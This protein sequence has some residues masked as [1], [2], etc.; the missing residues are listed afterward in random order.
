MNVQKF[1]DIEDTKVRSKIIREI[2]KK[3]GFNSKQISVRTIYPKYH[4]LTDMIL[5]TIKDKNIDIDNIKEIIGKYDFVSFD[6]NTKNV[7]YGYK[8]FFDID[9][10]Y[11]IKKK[12]IK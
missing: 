7:I 8:T 3:E 10:E 9:Y 6:M 4:L 11:S 12:F 5:V 1:F 2:L